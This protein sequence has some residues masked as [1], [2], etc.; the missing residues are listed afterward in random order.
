MDC[1]REGN[2]TTCPPILDGTSYACGKTKM[3]TFLKSLNNKSWEL[4]VVERTHPFVTSEDRKFTLK[5][6]V[7]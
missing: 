6:K 5:P 2:S 3:T 7:E 4:I 1:F